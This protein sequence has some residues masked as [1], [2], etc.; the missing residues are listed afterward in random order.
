MPGV[1][2]GWST[3]LTAHGTIPLSKALQPAIG[4]AKDGYAVS[5]IIA[6]QWEGT[7]RKLSADPAAAATFLPGGHAPKPGDVFTN[8]NLARD[9]RD[10]R[11]RRTRR[12]LQGSDRVSDRRGHEEA[13]RPARRDATS[14]RHKAEWVDPISTSYRGYDVLRDA[15]QLAGLRHPR[16]DEHPRGLRHQVARP[17]HRRATAPARRSQAHRLRRSRGLPRRPGSVPRGRAPDAHLEGVR[18]DAA[19]GDRSCA[20]CRVVQ[21]RD[22]RCD[23]NERRR[24]RANSTRTSP[25]AIAATRST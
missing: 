8:P 9:A 24:H 4:Y 1:V 25:D 22:D 18:R 19:Q 11:E 3:L 17:Q 16:D 21:G 15:A 10:D 6:K 23:E 5:E 13:R 2:D 14:R 12:V 20:C 7:E